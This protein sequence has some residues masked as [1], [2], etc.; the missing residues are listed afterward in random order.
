MGVATHVPLLTVGNAST[1]WTSPSSADQTKDGVNASKEFVKF[2]LPFVSL[3]SVKL[4]REYLGV[5]KVK[6]AFSS[7][8]N[9]S[10]C[11]R[12]SCPLSYHECRCHARTMD[13]KFFDEGKLTS[14]SI[15]AF[16]HLKPISFKRG[17]ANVDRF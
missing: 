7:C 17:T 6:S 8:W 14:M 16:M 13:V 11:R 3:K 2:N 12:V 5:N 1:V 4:E 10:R 9:F 15:N